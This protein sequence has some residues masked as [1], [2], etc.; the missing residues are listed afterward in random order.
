MS[1]V[2]RVLLS[3]LDDDDADRR[4]LCWLMT[5]KSAGEKRYVRNRVIGL[6]MNCSAKESM[7]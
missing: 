2:A 3:F 4:A 6:G 7:S 1:I 5:A